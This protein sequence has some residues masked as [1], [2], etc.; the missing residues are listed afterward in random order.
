[1][2]ETKISLL[3][4]SVAVQNE[5]DLDT[6]GMA[7]LREVFDRIGD[8]WPDKGFDV[9]RARNK[10]LLERITNLESHLNSLLLITNK[11]KALQKEFK[12]KLEEYERTVEMGIQYVNRHIK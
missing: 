11:P 1:M 9:L 4:K 7:K 5:A 8:R 3:V 10:P 2:P 12:A 6:E